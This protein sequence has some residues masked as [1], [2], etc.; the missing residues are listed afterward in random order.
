MAEP[1]DLSRFLED[2]RGFLSEL[3]ENNDR[4]WFH[5]HKSRYDSAL[6]R[7]AEKLLVEVAQGLRVHAGTTPRTKLFRP[8]RDVRFSEDKTPYHTHLHM[9]WSL[10]DG[11]AWML[12]L[13]PDYATAGVGVMQFENAQLDRFRDKVAGPEG[14][15]L[16]DIL[17]TGWRVDPPA[18]KRVPA[19]YPPEHPREVLLRFKGL[20]AWEDDLGQ[21]MSQDPVGALQE[22]F[23]RGAQIFEWLDG[24]A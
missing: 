6:K 23:D 21:A 3:S 16:Q 5:Q 7:P 19:P 10:P 11:R 15:A 17:D 20:V 9:M 13:A 8:H 22:V 4:G 18:L 12:G 1:I 14:A 2:T 24:V